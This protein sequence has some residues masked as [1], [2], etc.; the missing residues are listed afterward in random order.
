MGER[1]VRCPEGHS[2]GGLGA[3]VWQAGFV[4][5]GL[6]GRLRG[7]EMTGGLAREA[8]VCAPLRFSPT[9]FMGGESEGDGH[10]TLRVWQPSVAHFMGTESPSWR[11]Q[12]MSLVAA[13]VESN[14]MIAVKS[15]FT[16]SR[17]GCYHAGA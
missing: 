5:A 11:Q 13:S 4:S 1:A 12:R 7:I 6:A 10:Q 14:Q 8:G 17:C 16:H 15:G 2:G 9:H 3:K